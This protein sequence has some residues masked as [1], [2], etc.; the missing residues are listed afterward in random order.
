MHAAKTMAFVLA[1]ACA[2]TSVDAQTC[3]GGAGGGMDPTGNL[4]NASVESDTATTAGKAT[5][6]AS[7]PSAQA[8][9]ASKSTVAKPA[10]RVRPSLGS[11][12]HLRPTAHRA[13]GATN[14]AR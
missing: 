6:L 4:C 14:A 8:T 7:P 3:S 5:E 1:L 13:T 10:E 2:H 11:L 12:F 9:V